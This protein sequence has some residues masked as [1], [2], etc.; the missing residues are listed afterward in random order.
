MKKYKLSRLAKILIFEAILYYF[1]MA[2][3]V[4]NLYLPNPIQS[5]YMLIGCAVLQVAFILT[6]TVMMERKHLGTRYGIT[7]LFFEFGLLVTLVYTIYNLSL[8]GVFSFGGVTR[9]YPLF[10]IIPMLFMIAIIIVEIIY[11]NSAAKYAPAKPKVKK[12]KA[13]KI[14]E[15]EVLVSE[16]ELG[17]E[18]ANTEREEIGDIE[19]EVSEEQFNKATEEE[20]DDSLNPQPSEEPVVAPQEETIEDEQETEEEEVKEELTLE[21]ELSEEKV[22]EPKE[23]VLEE[24]TEEVAEE[25]LVPEVKE[26][27]ISGLVIVYNN[28]VNPGFEFLYFNTQ[29]KLVKSEKVRLDEDQ[30]EDGLPISSLNLQALLKSYVPERVKNVTVLLDSDKIYKVTN[31]YPKINRF[32]LKNIYQRDIKQSYGNTKEKHHTFVQEYHNNVETIIYTY[33]VPN[34]LYNFATKLARTL[35]LKVDVIDIYG[36]FLL[37]NI[38]KNANGNFLYAYEHNDVI[39]LIVSYDGLLTGMST[40]ENDEKVL[41]RYVYG[42]GMKHFYELEKESVEKLLTNS[43]TLECHVLETERLDIVLE[44]SFKVG[45]K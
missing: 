40:F 38:S 28:N 5:K 36:K 16:D 32:K 14:K 34:N 20:E 22:E 23:E 30:F 31:V 42:V 13:E 18:E 45:V 21:E 11:D 8:T 10:Y 27:K 35:N 24:T 44:A 15:E 6:L 39:T 7:N 17:G 19:P 12:I 33:F 3:E 29:K 2:L 1:G 4:L 41:D 9:T 37:D 25:A 26:E 43:K